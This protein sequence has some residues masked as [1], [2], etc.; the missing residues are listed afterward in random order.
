MAARSASQFRPAGSSNVQTLT[1]TQ[2]Y[3]QSR[4]RRDYV[5]TEV[6]AVTRCA[7]IGASLPSH[8]TSA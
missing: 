3:Q 8:R 6:L 7:D 4:S 5:G 1:A 2:P